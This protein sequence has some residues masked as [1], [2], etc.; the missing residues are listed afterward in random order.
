MAERSQLGHGTR[1]KAWQRRCLLLLA[2][3]G[4]RDHAAAFPSHEDAADALPTL[5]PSDSGNSGGHAGFASFDA[6]LAGESDGSPPSDTALPTLPP[7]AAAAGGGASF[8]ALPPG[9]AQKDLG[10]QDDL[11][12]SKVDDSAESSQ[13]SKTHDDT[14]M[15][16]D[17][18]G[19]ASDKGDKKHL[20]AKH[21]DDDYDAK[22]SGGPPPPPDAVSSSDSSKASEKRDS[23][24]SSDAARGGEAHKSSSSALTFDVGHTTGSSADER[25]DADKGSTKVKSGGADDSKGAS[26]DETSTKKK[27][28]AGKD[29]TEVKSG[30]ADDSKGASTDKTSTKKK[31]DAGKDSTEVKSGGA[32]DSKGA[33]TDKTSTKK[34]ADAGKDSTEVKSGGDD[35]A[36]GASAD[37]TSRKKKTDASKDSS[38]EKPDELKLGI[39][40][41]SS[42]DKDSSDAKKPDG[43]K[44]L[45]IGHS[46][47]SGKVSFADQEFKS[48]SSSMASTDNK[49]H[50]EH[51][52]EDA[53]H[54]S[55][56][57]KEARSK[58][59]NTHSASDDYEEDD[60]KTPGSLHAAAGRG[61]TT[62]GKNDEAGKNASKSSTSSFVAPKNATES[63]SK[64]ET[65][66]N[67]ATGKN[68]RAGKNASEVSNSSSVARKNATVSTSKNSSEAVKE[69]G[70]ASAAIPVLPS[71][72][73][74]GEA[75]SELPGNA[76]G[77]N[78]S[79][80]PGFL[81]GSTT[82]APG[83]WRES[84]STWSVQ[85]MGLL[86]SPVGSFATATSAWF[87]DPTS[88]QLAVSVS[89]AA[90]GGVLAF[91]GVLLWDYVLVACAGVLAA[92]FA[93]Y[94]LSVL[95]AVKG[96]SPIALCAALV[97]GSLGGLAT[98]QGIEGANVV[99]GALLGVALAAG[100]ASNGTVE[101]GSDGSVLYFV[102]CCLFAPLLGALTFGFKR[103]EALVTLAPVAG[104]FL[105]TSAVGTLLSRGAGA[106]W[107]IPEPA[108]STWV[109]VAKHLQGNAGMALLAFDCLVACVAALVHACSVPTS[110]GPGARKQEASHDVPH[111][112]TAVGIFVGSLVVS[113]G[114]GCTYL[115]GCPAWLVPEDFWQWSLLGGLLWAGLATAGVHVQ[116]KQLAKYLVQAE[117]AAAASKLEK[118]AKKQEKESRQ[119]PAATSLLPRDDSNATQPPLGTSP[120]T[121]TGW[122][123]FEG[124]FGMSSPGYQPSD[125]AGGRSSGAG[126]TGSP[127]PL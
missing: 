59:D 87:Q 15:S 116:L 26:A 57:A 32:D 111:L 35:D 60:E 67:N 93:V 45:D 19:G 47:G 31:A 105:L 73:P 102:A 108:G 107:L 44:Q 83:I 17:A 40:H 6:P 63:T 100:A 81:H 66:A 101:A 88:P 24:S 48:H 97:A 8:P 36:K 50:S 53:E 91:G 65:A 52:S 12:E 104:A 127:P 122:A 117:E 5:P 96:G 119:E 61:S 92:G 84:G 16:H 41:S 86:Q 54:L 2:A 124:G 11:G 78:A 69:P 34:K 62:A 95:E 23:S 13:G 14:T 90:L 85:Q 21:V 39:G 38:D 64:N 123:N 49:M 79:R 1:R 76:S 33:S 77:S 125:G 115:A 58:K 94:E 114:L 51:D 9:V 121:E 7:P 27:A 109:G 82:V 56:P 112:I 46:S 42:S 29:S 72:G 71:L 120:S 4:A 3:A 106:T 18:E 118:K 126:R 103:R 20:D 99:F 55:S 74:L 75:V 43:L 98:H 110:S 80:S 30:G 68:D 113:T 28:D 10:L 25:S 70:N 89:V 22:P 37:K